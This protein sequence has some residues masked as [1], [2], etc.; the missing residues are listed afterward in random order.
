MKK[1]HTV[2]G[3]LLFFIFEHCR[4]K[5]IGCTNSDAL[6]FN[7]SATVSDSSCTYEADKFVGN[8][9]GEDIVVYDHNGVGVL[10]YNYYYPKQSFKIVREN[11]KSIRIS[12]LGGCNTDVS[13]NKEYLYNH[14]F[15]NKIELQSVGGCNINNFKAE[16]INDTLSYSYTKEIGVVISTLTGQPIK[17]TATGK[18]IRK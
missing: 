11:N 4:L 5:E 12:N 2:F 10:V 7:A 14:Y 1:V 9:T 3:I 17:V 13:A 16:L 6:N 18:A 8:Y 15:D